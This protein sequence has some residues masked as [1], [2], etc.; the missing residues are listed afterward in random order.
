[1]Y[2]FKCAIE[3]YKYN[4]STIMPTSMYLN[5]FFLYRLGALISKQRQ[6]LSLWN[7]PILIGVA[8]RKE[9]KPGKTNLSP[10]DS[11]KRRINRATVSNSRKVHKTRSKWFII[12]QL[13]VK[14]H[15]ACCRKCYNVVI[16]IAIE[17]QI[18]YH[19]ARC[20]MHPKV[21]CWKQ[22]T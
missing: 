5:T 18:L 6:Y 19:I 20:S 2:C 21:S 14:N 13:I 1:M 16:N 17:V 9:W 10:K 11:E 22:W 8:K 7:F 15:F 12:E 3:L 4:V